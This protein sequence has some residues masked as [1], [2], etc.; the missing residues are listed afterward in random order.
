MGKELP[1]FTKQSSERV[2]HFAVQVFTHPSNPEQSYFQA[3]Q[4]H[5]DKHFSVVFSLDYFENTTAPTKSQWNS[6]KK[7]FKRHDKRIFVFKEHLLVRC[8]EEG[9]L[10]RCGQIEFG[11]MREFSLR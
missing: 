8:G 5:E 2:K 1:Q 6:L 7:K 3:L 10:L 11:Y 4:E 9:D